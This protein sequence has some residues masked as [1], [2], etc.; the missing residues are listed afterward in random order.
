M[1]GDIYLTHYVL[2]IF[3]V[4][5]AIRSLSVKNVQLH[6]NAQKVTIESMQNWEVMTNISVAC[7][8]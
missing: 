5:F 7:A 1:Y 3:Q 4:S 8:C 6:G 2:N